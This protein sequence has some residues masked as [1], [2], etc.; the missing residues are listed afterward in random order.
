M[1]T[2]IWTRCAG[3]A[4]VA[5]LCAAPALAQDAD[6]AN[7][8][9][10]ND[11]NKQGQFSEQ[12]QPQEDVVSNKGKG[13]AAESNDF[14]S[15]RQ[16]RYGRYQHH[17]QHR[18]QID[19]KAHSGDTNAAT[20]NVDTKA[21]EAG[22]RD[23]N[24]KTNQGKGT[25]TWVEWRDAERGWAESDRYWRETDRHWRSS[26]RASDP[27]REE[28]LKSSDAYWQDSDDFWNEYNT[29]QDG[30]VSQTNQGK[31]TPETESEPNQ[32]NDAIGP[33]GQGA[34]NPSTAPAGATSGSGGG[35]SAS[36]GGASGG[37]T[38]NQGKNS[39]GQ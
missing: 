14:D 38:A 18:Y 24:S 32:R 22:A 39:G 34:E 33:D 9:E 19:G 29:N 35:G 23:T 13:T 26:D 4:A 12:D 15:E 7:K 37:T 25:G 2:R 30:K 6:K 20:G 8:D 36:G 16:G 3:F 17:M 1:A 10:K 27:G 21:D 5:A 11:R 28:Y 31:G